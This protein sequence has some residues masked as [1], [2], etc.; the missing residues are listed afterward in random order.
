MVGMTAPAD[1]VV[2]QLSV[3]AGEA[4]ESADF[5]TVSRPGGFWPLR[6]RTD[7]FCALLAPNRPGQGALCRQLLDVME[8]E[9]A[10]SGGRSATSALAGALM[11]AH[12][13]LRRENALSLADDRVLMSAAAVVLRGG[14]AYVG[15]VGAAFAAVRHEGTLQR[16]AGAATLAEGE[17]QG[18]LLGD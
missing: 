4:Q 7:Q 1:L 12:N 10:A 17:E 8:R 18:G 5:V 6:R 3:E 16:F 13:H 9:F 14:G 2:T 15:R 11:A